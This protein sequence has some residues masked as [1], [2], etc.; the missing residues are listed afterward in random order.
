MFDFLTLDKS[1]IPDI[2]ELEKICFSDPY[3]KNTLEATADSERDVAFVCTVNGKAIGYIELGDFIDTLCVNRIAVLPEYRKNGIAHRLLEMAV[4][5]AKI[6]Q[7]GELSLEV[8]AS[9]SAARRLY[10]KFGFT[11][12]GKRPNYYRDPKEDAAV[13]IMK[14]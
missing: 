1:H 2:A 6:K 14:L 13:Y 12:A 7:I 3:S 5:A 9:N 10:E 4:E 11:L 8:R